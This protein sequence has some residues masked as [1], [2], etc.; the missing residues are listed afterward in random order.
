MKTIFLVGVAAVL[1][2]TSVA[3]VRRSALPDNQFQL[4]TEN[5]T[6]SQTQPAASHF[7]MT[8]VAKGEGWM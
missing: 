2:A 7:T 3:S 8:P 6:M 1:L 5:V 4:A